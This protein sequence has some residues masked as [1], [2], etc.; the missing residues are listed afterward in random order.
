MSGNSLSKTVKICVNTNISAKF[1]FKNTN[2]TNL[3]SSAFH[4]PFMSG[5]SKSRKANFK[6]IEGKSEKISRFG[7]L[8]A[9]LII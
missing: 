3:F 7:L 4:H 6:L 9:N 8:S 5:S 2:I 1:Q